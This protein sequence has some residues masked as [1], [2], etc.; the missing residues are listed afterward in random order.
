[1]FGVIS[2]FIKNKQ[3]NKQKQK[4]KQT[5]KKPFLCRQDGDTY[6]GAK[7]FKLEKTM[8]NTCTTN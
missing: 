4:N 6:R 5:T 1:M 8:V 2:C 3:T 7:T